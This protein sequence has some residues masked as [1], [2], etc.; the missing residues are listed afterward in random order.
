MSEIDRYDEFLGCFFG[1]SCFF[2]GFFEKYSIF[3]W[4]MRFFVRFCLVGYLSLCAERM[5]SVTR[6]EVYGFYGI[7]SS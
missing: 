7:P 5:P 4:K 1:K 2:I 3:F 6:A